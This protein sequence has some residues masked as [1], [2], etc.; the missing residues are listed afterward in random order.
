M[1]ELRHDA[2]ACRQRASSELIRK[3]LG[4]ETPAEREKRERREAETA[5]ERRKAEQRGTPLGLG[6][7]DE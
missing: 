4:I 1:G 3:S 5:A 2:R 7:G 6:E